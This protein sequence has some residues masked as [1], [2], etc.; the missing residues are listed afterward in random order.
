MLQIYCL[1][2]ELS[3]YI[4][5]HYV[6]LRD[7]Y[8]FI[9]GRYVMIYLIVYSC[10]MLHGFITKLITGVPHGDIPWIQP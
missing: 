8:C 7:L 6:G 5:S 3:K 10:M 1:L 4:V 2:N 9:I